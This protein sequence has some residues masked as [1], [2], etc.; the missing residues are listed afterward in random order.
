M[1]D[2]Q[3][4]IIINRDDDFGIHDVENA[5]TLYLPYSAIPYLLVELEK[6]KELTCNQ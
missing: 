4:Y 6:L 5:D 3:R 1:P 2:G